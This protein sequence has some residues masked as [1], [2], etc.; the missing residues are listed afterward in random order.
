MNFER[1]SAEYRNFLGHW[2]AGAAK[3]GRAVVALAVLLTVVAAVHFADAIT[4]NTSTN[5]MLSKD[6]PF[7]QYARELDAAFPQS[8]DTLVVVIKGQT[9]GLADD[10]A[11]ALGARLRAM[12]ALFENVYDLRG[13]AFFRENG[14]LYL[15]VDELYELSDALADAQ[16]FLGK[17][18]RER[19][20]AGRHRGRRTTRRT[21]GTKRRIVRIAC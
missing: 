11:L 15:S 5:D 7:R 17:L 10:A 19:N 21:T 13:D 20:L 12:P 14:L 1:A 2:V 3:R 6:V 18:W 8:G 4:I 16:P 9:A